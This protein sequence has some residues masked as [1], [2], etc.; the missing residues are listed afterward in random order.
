MTTNPTETRIDGKLYLVIAEC[1][2]TATETVEKKL[3]RLICRHASDTKSYQSIFDTP[4]A[5]CEIVR[6]HGTAT[7][8]K[9]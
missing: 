5:M 2:P 9:E 4:L 6:E 1:S 3:E 8:I 7:N